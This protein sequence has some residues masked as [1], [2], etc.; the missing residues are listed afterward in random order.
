MAADIPN[1]LTDIE[2]RNLISNDPT[3]NAL[4][5]KVQEN[6][7]ALFENESFNNQE[8]DIKERLYNM[9]NYAIGRFD[10]YSE[11][12]HKFLN[13][14]LS[15]IGVSATFI[16][17]LLSNSNSI[18]SFL[19]TCGYID[20][21]ILSIAG[22]VMIFFYNSYMTPNYPYRKIMDIHSWYFKYKFS[23]K[24]DYRLSKRKK[25]ADRQLLEVT[26]SYMSSVYNWTNKSKIKNYFIKEDIE[27]V[28]ILQ[29][30][31]KY[32]W[33]CVTKMKTTM[34]WGI[35]LFIAVPILLLI[36]N[37]TIMLLEYLGNK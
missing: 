21:V 14:G 36:K 30:L 12:K 34:N 4:K 8:A 23:D 6:L 7:R 5:L 31:Q 11:Q 16:G 1:Q 29:L 26:Q 27:Q 18:P 19:K 22:V 3:Y 24:L 17:I 20:S 9:I 28:A 2:I 37:F 13:I 32:S 35:A 10:Y 25:K 15:F 33:D